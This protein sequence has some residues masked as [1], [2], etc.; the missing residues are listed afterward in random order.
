LGTF[1]RVDAVASKLTHH[2]NQFTL[3]ILL[4]HVLLA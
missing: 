4:C 3:R 2:T 1:S